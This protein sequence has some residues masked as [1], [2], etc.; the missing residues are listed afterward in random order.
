MTRA[1]RPWWLLT[2]IPA[3]AACV[4]RAPYQQIVLGTIGIDA[5]AAVGLAIT[6]RKAGQPS[7]AQTTFM[8]IG[9]YTASL[10][11]LNLHWPLI[12]AGIAGVIAAAASAWIFGA[13]LLN[14]EGLYFALG[15]LA[16]NAAAVAIFRNAGVFGNDEGLQGL[17]ALRIP[18]LTAEQA[19]T[20]VAWVLVALGLWFATRLDRARFGR[21]LRMLRESPKVAHSVGFDPA[22]LKRTAFTLSGA[23]AGAAGVLLAAQ[24]SVVNPTLFSLSN[25]I[26]LLAMVITG[27]EFLLATVGGAI[28]IV[29]VHEASRSA[30][31]Y[32]PV[33]LVG[34]IDLIVNGLVLVLILR[35]WSRG[36]SSFA[37]RRRTARTV[38]ERAG[39][40][41]QL[42]PLSVTPG[43]PVLAAADIAHRFGGVY[44]V[45]GVSL[46]VAAGEIVAVIGP[47]GAGKTTLLSILGGYLPIQRGE[48]DLDHRPIE[49]LAPFQRARRGIAATFQHMEVVEQMSVRENVLASGTREAAVAPALDAVGLADAADVP[50]SELSFGQQRM[51][52]LARVLARDETPRVLLMDEPASGLSQSERVTL[53]GVVR[54]F[55]AA[56]TA[57]VLVEHDV[58]FVA[59]LA[60]RILVLDHGVPI[61]EGP[62]DSLLRQQVVIDA[63]LGSAPVPA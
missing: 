60:D 26:A 20:V 44:A 39:T 14:L 45:D 36:L 35:F 23:Y 54:A 4:I 63:Y 28:V 7:L 47:N 61:A 40:P 57:I 15:T 41:A 31:Q 62:P 58:G 1:P 9:A 51:V 3:L 59:R 10:L 50:V 21:G 5:I 52:E 53:A 18:G 22:S 19:P 32:A 11:E 16:L 6:L 46:A 38:T 37:M 48:V 27:G 2:L 34:G 30:L 33:T 56:G 12:P 29:L 25:S 13:I 55:A 17:T 49:D 24:L 42:A 8:A 43:T